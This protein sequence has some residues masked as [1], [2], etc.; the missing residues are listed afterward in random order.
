MISG[1]PSCTSRKADYSPFPDFFSLYRVVG[2]QMRIKRLKAVRMAYDDASSVASLSS[3]ERNRSGS[4]RIYR[5]C[6]LHGH[7]NTEVEAASAGYGMNPGSV[8]A[9]Y[10]ES[11][12]QGAGKRDA[13][14]NSVPHE[15][16][17]A[18]LK[19]LQADTFLKRG[20]KQFPS[21]RGCDGNRNKQQGKQRSHRAILLSILSASSSVS[22]SRRFL[23]TSSA[24]SRDLFFSL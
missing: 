23:N 6:Q 9:A 14:K 16:V 8:S 10:P 12:F 11:L 7:V 17:P 2:S 3:R 4:R 18:G 5:G 15:Y 21:V 22:C 20:I 1:A 13:F 24:P 19:A